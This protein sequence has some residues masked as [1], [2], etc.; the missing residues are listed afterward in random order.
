MDLMSELKISEHQK[1]EAIKVIAELRAEKK[2][3]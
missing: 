1:C 3:Y 2:N